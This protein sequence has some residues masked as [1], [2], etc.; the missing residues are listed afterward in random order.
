MAKKVILKQNGE[1]IQP[2]VD[3]TTVVYNGDSNVGDT[4]DKTETRLKDFDGY[5]LIESDD[6][7]LAIVNSDGEVAFGISRANG[8]VV[9]PMG[10]PEEQIV[11]N[12]KLTNRIIALEKKIAT[13]EGA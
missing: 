3:A 5:Q 13:L 6:Y 10:I 2:I 12:R 11:E 7:V 4:L 9:I 8:K 1:Q